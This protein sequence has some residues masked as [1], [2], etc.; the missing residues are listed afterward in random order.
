MPDINRIEH[1]VYSLSEVKRR[2]N[3]HG[4]MS[5]KTAMTNAA[6]FYCPVTPFDKNEYNAAVFQALVDL[7][8][9]EHKVN[10]I[11]VKIGGALEAPVRQ[12]DGEPR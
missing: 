4:E 12:S 3:W 6:S 11:A 5:G 2:N 1:A 7:T 9:V 8:L 10:H